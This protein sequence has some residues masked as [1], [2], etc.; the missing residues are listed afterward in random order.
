LKDRG[1]AAR[2]FGVAHTRLLR[3]TL[4]QLQARRDVFGQ[5][6]LLLRIRLQ[7]IEVDAF[8][9]GLVPRCDRD[10]QF[11]VRRIER[12][13]LR[14]RQGHAQ[15]PIQGSDLDAVMVV[16]SRRFLVRHANR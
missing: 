5:Q 6:R 4:N 8:E 3:H 14:Q 12:H 9:P 13:R 2:A 16:H 1:N 7:Q 11:A 15:R 10:L